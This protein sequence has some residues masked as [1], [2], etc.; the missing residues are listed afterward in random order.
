MKTKEILSIFALVAIVLCL[1]CG[2]VKMTIKSP[3]QKQSCDTA[4]ALLVF[5]A[6]VLVGISQ[7]LDETVTGGGGP[8]PRPSSPLPGH[9]GAR[10]LPTGSDTSGI[11]CLD[12]SVCKASGDY[13]V[14]MCVTPK[15][16]GHVVP[17]P[18]PG[19]G[20]GPGPK[21]SSGPSPSPKPGQPGGA[22]IPLGSGIGMPCNLG[23]HCDNLLPP[24]CVKNPDKPPVPTH[25]I[26]PN[27]GQLGGVCKMATG[28]NQCSRGLLCKNG[29]CVLGGPCTLGKC[30][31]GGRCALDPISDKNRC[32]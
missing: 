31:N 10:C 4:C 14:K 22:C 19:P 24:K 1:I 3:K 2:V 9:L 21:P 15:K 26:K 30:P 18:G 13:G 16:H 8:R 27:P 17:S 23:S 32:F 12:G 5:V 25:F 29:K 28:S 6:V 20:P 11:P 7:L